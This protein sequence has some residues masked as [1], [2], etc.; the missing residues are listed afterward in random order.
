M[1]LEEEV[2][3]LLL[4]VADILSRQISSMPYK[5]QT[6]PKVRKIYADTS[7]L[8]IEKVS[9]WNR[10]EELFV[11]TREQFLESVRLGIRDSIPK[12][13]EVELYRVISQGVENGVR[14]FLKRG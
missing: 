14:K 5:Q 12:L 7:Y 9:S 13:D 6:D 3:Q 11:N 8:V 2:S 4:E 10:Q 1:T